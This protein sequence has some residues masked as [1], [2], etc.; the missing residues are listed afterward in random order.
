MLSLAFRQFIGVKAKNNIKKSS[1]I[2]FGLV[3]L[4]KRFFEVKKIK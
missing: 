2:I 1:C 4:I 3:L